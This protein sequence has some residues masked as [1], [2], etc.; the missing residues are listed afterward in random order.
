MLYNH[1]AFGTERFEAMKQ[2]KINLDEFHKELAISRGWNEHGFKSAKE[3]S[4]KDEID[5]LCPK[6][7]EK[8]AD[9]VAEDLVLYLHCL[10]YTGPDWKFKS[11][12]PEWTSE[13][14][15]VPSFYDKY[16]KD[17]PENKKQ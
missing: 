11:E 13:D 1:H 3:Q 5:P 2:K 17:R 4:N 8:P 6:C 14:Y 10:C 7:N 12:M 15:V 16:L 9:P